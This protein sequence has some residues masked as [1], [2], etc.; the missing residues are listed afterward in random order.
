M[1]ICIV[2]LYNKQERL[3]GNGANRLIN[4]LT[5]YRMT[6]LIQKSEVTKSNV[7]YTKQLTAIMPR[8]NG[9][10]EGLSA[11]QASLLRGKGDVK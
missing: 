4:K 2:Y 8:N 9:T 3:R 5:N 6:N 1:Q 7:S 10:P 11:L